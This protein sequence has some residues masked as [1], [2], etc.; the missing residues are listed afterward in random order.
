MKALALI[1]LILLAAILP[2]DNTLIVHEWGT[3][4]SVAG[5][6][7]AALEWRPLAAEDDLPSF[8]YGPGDLADGAGVRHDPHLKADLSALVRMETPVIYFYAKNPL[9]VSVRVAFPQGKVTEWYPRVRSVSDRDGI[10]WGHITVLPDTPVSFLTETKP[11]HYYAARETDAATVRVCSYSGTQ[12]EKFLFYRGV[13][14]FK[15]PV[16]ATLDGNRV[17]VTGARER[18][19]VFENRGGRIGWT[20]SDGDCARPELNGDLHALL[21]ELEK[22]LTEHGLYPK[23]TRAMVATW[24]DS[25]FEEGLRVFY[26]LPRPITD[27]VL[28][29]TLDPKPAELVRVLVG[30]VELITPEMEQAMRDDPA[31][32]KRT[33]GRFAEAILKR[34]AAHS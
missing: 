21:A 28:P 34:L 14:S 20:V 4:T 22:M 13:G 29:L 26:V 1:P 9:E 17:H 19:I 27:K 15:L 16:R 11:S 3:F 30:R 7:G 32:A 5:E 2:A 33:Y 18:V 6:D 10:D 8:V 25:W 31:S 23:E 24:R 12:H